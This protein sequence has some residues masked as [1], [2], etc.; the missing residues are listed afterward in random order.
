MFVTNILRVFDS[1][2]H[3]RSWFYDIVK[4]LLYVGK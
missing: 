1:F 4:K 3:K 2:C